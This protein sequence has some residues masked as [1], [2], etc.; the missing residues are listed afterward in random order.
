M[1]QDTISPYQL[2][3]L[4]M[5]TIGLLNHV[6]IIP[7]LLDAAGRDGWLSVIIGLGLLVPYILLLYFTMSKL[8]RQH[9]YEWLRARFGAFVARLYAT[10]ASLYLFWMAALTLADT[11]NWTRISYFPQSPAI[12]L[13]I[14]LVGLCFYNAHSGIRSIAL[15][16]GITLPLVVLFG[17]FVMSANMQHKDYKNILPM[18]ENGWDPIW[19]G[20]LFV[21]SGLAELT[22]VLFQQHHL[23]KLPRTGGLLFLSVM[24]AGLIVGPLLGSISEFGLDRSQTMRYPAYEEWR[25]VSLGRYIEHL[26]FLSIYQWLS[27]AYTRISL[28]MFLIPDLY[29]VPVS[30]KRTVIM[31]GLFLLLA[32]T[33]YLPYN[34][35]M[36]VKAL[37]TILPVS[38]VLSFTLAVTLFV[39]VVFAKNKRTVSS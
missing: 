22:I 23:R 11:V 4:L 16:A 15:S 13:A 5:L 10:L 27:G 25:L 18:L 37:S 28:T 39:M 32:V 2:G 29:M 12:F 1:K 9:P 34:D 19:H 30:K 17:F 38:M 36:F 6:I 31:G 8:Q 33:I 14:L 3:T 7:L 35:V 21:C 20:V 24:L 26:D